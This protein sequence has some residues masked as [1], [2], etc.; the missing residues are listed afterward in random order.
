MGSILIKNILLDGQKRNVLIEGQRFRSLSAADGAVAE[1]VLDGS[2][3]ALLPGL[4]NAHTHSAMTLMRGYGD[5][6]PLEMWLNQYIWPFEAR[7]TQCEIRKGYDLAT[8]EM[9]QTGTVFFNDMYFH[10][11]D[12]V[13]AV[14]KSGLRACLSVVA[15]NGH[16]HANI[17]AELDFLKQWR[18]PTGGRIQFAMA[19]HAIYTVP[20]EK[21]LWMTHFARE[22]EMKIHIHLSETRTEVEDCL[23]AHGMRPI[24]YLD[25]LGVLGPDVIAAHCVHVT[26]EEADILAERQVTIVHCPC[27][28]MKLGSGIFSYERLIQAGCR[29]TL[30]TD[31]ASSSNN[32]DLREA[33]KFAAMLAKV[34]G[35]PQLLPAQQV[36]DWATRCGAE[37]FGIDAGVIAEGKLADA[38]LVDLENVKMQPCHSLISNF[39]YSADSSCIAGV[40]CDGKLIYQKS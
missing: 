27:S 40:L 6:T 35:N 5:D 9:V 36:F 20:E 28:N 21:L 4:Y 16:P 38:I 25:S 17:E 19:P 22:H 30:G 1:T 24:A 34:G 10:I 12:A 7:L 18:D 26:Q 15:L 39:V 13:Q 32:L 11:D 8:R 23:K 2:G 3:K 29:I 37:A 31:G 33:M 14:E